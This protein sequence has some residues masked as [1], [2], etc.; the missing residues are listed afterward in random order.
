MKYITNFSTGKHTKK[1]SDWPYITIAITGI[2]GSGKSEFS[3]IL[4]KQGIIVIDTDKLVKDVTKPG[5]A[6]LNKLAKAIGHNIILPDNSLNR[7]LLR[8]LISS[9][10]A[11]K[12]R[13]EAL[14]HPAV[15]T[16]LDKQLRNA[17]KQGVKTAAVE[18]PLLFEAGWEPYFD[19]TVCIVAPETECIK[20]IARRNKI[21]E[22]EAAQWLKIQMSQDE[23][24]SKADYIISNDGNKE[25]LKLKT[26]SLI[27]QIKQDMQQ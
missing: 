14:I 17:A 23:K 18:V 13:V 15:F 21:S 27:S 12:K 24:K 26:N 8:Q 6:I 3:K 1:P 19:K 16:L 7:E 10:K 4:S 9:D 2:P 11:L 20:R 5:A 22:A 25:A